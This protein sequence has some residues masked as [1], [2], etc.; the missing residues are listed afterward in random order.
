MFFD[1]MSLYLLSLSS[2]KILSCLKLIYRICIIINPLL[3]TNPYV[4]LYKR[5]HLNYH[6]NSSQCSSTLSQTR[7]VSIV[8]ATIKH[9]HL[10]GSD[11]NPYSRTPLN[12]YLS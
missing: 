12:P 7:H 4:V 2:L 1:F 5:T 3:F 6:N 11:A 10:P 8:R 9:L